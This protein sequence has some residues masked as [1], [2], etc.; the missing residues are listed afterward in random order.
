GNILSAVLM[1]LTATLWRTLAGVSLSIGF[2]YWNLFPVYSDVSVMVSATV[3]NNNKAPE[4]LAVDPNTVPVVLG[5]N[6]IQTF[7]VQI[8]D[9]DSPS[10]SYTITAGTGATTPINGTITDTVALTSGQA[11]INFTYFT[12][13]NKAGSS[14]IT[15]TLNDGSTV[16]VKQISTYI[17]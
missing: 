6:K 7:S 13:P 1:K 3:G 17:F 14:N 8:K 12:P 11:F 16:I 9:T 4:I 15:V 2:L 10:V 5:K